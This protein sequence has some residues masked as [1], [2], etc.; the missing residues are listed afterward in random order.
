MTTPHPSLRDTFSSQGRRDIIVFDFRGNTAK[1]G[2]FHPL[3]E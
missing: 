3:A 1:N 2:R